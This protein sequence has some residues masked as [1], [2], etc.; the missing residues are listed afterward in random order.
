MKITLT[1]LIVLGILG[2]KIVHAEETYVEPGRFGAEWAVTEDTVFIGPTYKSDTLDA[3]LFVSGH[4]FTDGAAVKSWVINTRL[5]YRYNLGS[6]NYLAGGILANY[7][8]SGQDFGTGVGSTFNNTKSVSNN[9]GLSVA[10]SGRIGPYLAIQRHFAHSGVFVEIAVMLYAYQTNKMNDGNDNL[11][12]S[13]AN[14]FLESGYVGMGYL[15]GT[16]G[17]DLASK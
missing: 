17:D 2:Q 11:V 15:F 4:S 12:T 3:A 14:R 5:G 10:G 1:L 9:K 16:S 6:H 8:F 7:V 13:H